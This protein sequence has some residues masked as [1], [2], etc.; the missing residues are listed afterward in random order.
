MH[1]SAKTD[2]FKTLNA[3]AD[4]TWDQETDVGDD[5]LESFGI[6]TRQTSLEEEDLPDQKS[7]VGSGADLDCG[8]SE[9]SGQQ[10][11]ILN[12]AIAQ[13]ENI[14][15]LEKLPGRTFRKTKR[16]KYFLLGS[17]N[18]GEACQFAH[19][20][21]VSARPN[22]FRTR[23]CLAFDRFGHCKDGDSCKYAHGVE[24]LRSSECVDGET[25]TSSSDR[26]ETETPSDISPKASE[27][28]S[29]FSWC[30]AQARANVGS[31]FHFILSALDNTQNRNCVTRMEAE[32]S[33][34][35][36]QERRASQEALQSMLS[37]LF[38]A[39]CVCD[40]DGQLTS[41]TPQLRE[42][43][44]SDD[45]LLG[46]K[47]ADFAASKSEEECL[48]AF[49]QRAGENAVREAAKT[50]V[51][52]QPMSCESR[53]PIEF[54]VYAVKLPEI[55]QLWQDEKME[56]ADCCA[57]EGLSVGLQ[58]LGLPAVRWKGETGI[59]TKITSKF[60]RR[61]KPRT[62]A[63]LNTR[64]QA[65][66]Q[67]RETPDHTV[68]QMVYDAMGRMNPRGKGCCFYHVALRVLHRT[69]VAT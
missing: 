49:L 11:G 67:F 20:S 50:R 41:C 7:L 19:T 61:T 27:S 57:V 60:C 28:A 44:G 59:Q 63:V 55:R 12:L 32:M 54:I 52:L 29:I 68:E 21:E 69:I 58:S 38:D 24:Q 43:L 46:C 64:S 4:D 40:S 39:S 36:V 53:Q 30:V 65:L 56:S 1:D 3:E 45:P 23:L 66:R 62:R 34:T 48:C 14:A 42:L 16:C 18:K 6:T 51:C 37:S 22:L 9:A 8:G 17:C 2:G 31:C 35:L 25:A 33:E 5:D 13:I 26:P 10:E 15:P 47:L